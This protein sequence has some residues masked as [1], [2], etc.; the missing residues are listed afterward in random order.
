MTELK[1]NGTDPLMDRLENILEQLSVLQDQLEEINEK[2][3]DISL[4]NEGF[5]YSETES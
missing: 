3:A 2:L 5:G 1:S 4:T